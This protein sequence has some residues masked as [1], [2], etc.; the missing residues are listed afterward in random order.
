MRNAIQW[1][2]NWFKP[3]WT[4]AKLLEIA[5]RHKQALTEAAEA[6]ELDAGH[7][8]EVTETWKELQKIQP[9]P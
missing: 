3:H 6:A 5:N 7:D 2:P 9:T 8:P 4:L 1:A